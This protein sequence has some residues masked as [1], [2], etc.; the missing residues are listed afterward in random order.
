MSLIRK[1]GAVLQAWACLALVLPRGFSGDEVILE[2][3]R[4]VSYPV[5]LGGSLSPVLK[6][7]PYMKALNCHP[8]SVILK[9]RTKMASVLF[10][11]NVSAIQEFKEPTNKPTFVPQNTPDAETLENFAK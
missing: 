10:P 8:N 5:L 4:T 6:G 1:H 7:I 2:P 11:N 3:L 9:R